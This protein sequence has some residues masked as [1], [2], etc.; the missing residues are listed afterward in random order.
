M[1]LYEAMMEK[2]RYM[3]KE[4]TPDGLGGFI[5]T[6]TPGAEFPAAIHKDA[7]VVARAAEKD[8][9][10]EV[11]TITVSR[12]FPLGFHD[13]IRRESDGMILRVTS[14]I[15]DNTSPVFSGIDFGQV[16]AEAYKLT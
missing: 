2:C 9:L 16:N 8:G 14:E 7:S 15:T 4:K 1:M 13:V 6:W 5:D 3:V 10:T 12:N 11:Y